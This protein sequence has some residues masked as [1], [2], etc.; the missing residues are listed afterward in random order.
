MVWSYILVGCPCVFGRPVAIKNGVNWG[1][2]FAIGDTKAL[3]IVPWNA[4]FSRLRGMFHFCYLQDRRFYQ[5]EAHVFKNLFLR[6]DFTFPLIRGIKLLIGAR[7]WHVLVALARFSKK[8]TKKKNRHIWFNNNEAFKL[9]HKGCKLEKKIAVFIY[10]TIIV[11][12]VL[13][14]RFLWKDWIKHGL[15]FYC[16]G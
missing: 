2:V 3:E 6:W 16:N 12:Y 7:D 15:V 13:R 4:L 9:L 14:M 8:T 1:N 5:M 10:L 11:F